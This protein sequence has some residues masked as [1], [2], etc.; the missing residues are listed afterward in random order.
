MMRDPMRL[1]SVT[2]VGESRFRVEVVDDD[3][4]VLDVVERLI[5]RIPGSAVDDLLA[6]RPVASSGH[7][8]EGAAEAV[9][10]ALGGRRV[11]RR[12]VLMSGGALAAGGI[13][14]LGLPF[15]AAAASRALNLSGTETE[16]QAISGGTTN[17]TFLVGSAIS[18]G[19]VQVL[20]R[21][22]RGGDGGSSQPGSG[23]DGA[24]IAATIS[25]IPST[26][27]RLYFRWGQ[28][29]YAD[30]ATN[31]IPSLYGGSGGSAG[32]VSWSAGGS[33]TY[34]AVA[35][36]G[37]G[38]GGGASGGD[39][40]QPGGGGA[41]GGGAG[42]ASAV[43][44]PG[45]SPGGNLQR[46]AYAGGPPENGLPGNRNSHSSN[47]GGVGASHAQPRRLGGGGGAGYYQGGGGY[48]ESAADE[49]DGG[50]GGGGSTYFGTTATAGVPR[51]TS[52]RVFP[53]GNSLSQGV[54]I[55]V[56]YDAA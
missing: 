14:T 12:K 13:V 48:G 46:A 5:H 28:G 32:A 54:D 38:A 3:V 55:T 16:L 41:A 37:G 4:L 6:G 9:R 26:A 40:G 45:T 56:Y 49:G 53:F 47:S 25:S 2:G 43:G 23:G 35:G 20:V 1:T 30:D 31:S 17:T 51:V 34:L 10:A 44:Q 42:T 29:G 15:A 8:P 19:T 36:G 11:A 33:F 21:A 24:Y 7:L 27:D 50:G 39:F 22:T 18:G 52:S